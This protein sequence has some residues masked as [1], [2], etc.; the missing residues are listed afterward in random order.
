MY[1]YLHGL[2]QE[3]WSPKIVFVIPPKISVP[4][5]V[6]GVN[7]IFEMK[8]KVEFLLKEN[9]L[10]CLLT[11]NLR[12]Y[13]NIVFRCQTVV[14]SVGHRCKNFKS[15]WLHYKKLGFCSI[16][17]PLDRQKKKKKKALIV[18]HS[19]VP[20]SCRKKWCH[21]R[22]GR[23]LPATTTHLRGAKATTNCNVE[24]FKK[25]CDMCVEK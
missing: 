10:L 9:V 2:A 16:Q 13:L 6:D 22:L 1:N 12:N 21:K 20:L 5:A 7:V 17:N 24:R 18:K 3:Y 4:I 8:Y 15:I 23:A 11:W 25:T 19:C 14:H